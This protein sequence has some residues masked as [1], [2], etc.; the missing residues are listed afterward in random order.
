MKDATDQMLE[1]FLQK[2]IGA[3]P[4]FNAC[5]EISRQDPDAKI[6]VIAP[7]DTFAFTKTTRV[8]RVQT[9]FAKGTIIIAMTTYNDP[10]ATAAV[11]RKVCIWL[12]DNQLENTIIIDPA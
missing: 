5:A 9:T 3:N 2:M 8:E 1:I 6:V 10:I 12:P 11:C 7:R 4:V